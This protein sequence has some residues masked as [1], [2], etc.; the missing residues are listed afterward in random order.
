MFYRAAVALCLVITLPTVTHVQTA[1][2]EDQ[3]PTAS[4]TTE[5]PDSVAME[6]PITGDHWTYQVHDEITGTLKNTSTETVTDVTPTEISIRTETVGGSGAAYFVYDRLW[7][8]KSSPLWKF[9]PNDGTGVKL[10]LEVGGAWKAQGDDLY[11]GHSAT[12]RRSASSKVVGEETI[13]TDAGT[14]HT[15][16]IET[17]IATRNIHDPAKKAEAKITSWF[18]R[19]V[20]HWVKRI[21]KTEANGHVTQNV[22]VVLVDCGRR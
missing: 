11:G 12:A 17:E 10:P 7:N 8:M 16:K 20:D 22:S 6:Q 2:A 19:S 13:T 4:P 18:A 1:L 14:F 21:M 5:P 3:L 9:S 15:F